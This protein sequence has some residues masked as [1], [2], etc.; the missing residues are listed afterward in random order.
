MTAPDPR[1]TPEP[2][3][4]P[5]IAALALLVA[6]AATAGLALHP[7]PALAAGGG[8]WTASPTAPTSG[9]SAT[10][11]RVTDDDAAADDTTVDDDATADDSDVPVGDDDPTVAV[12]DSGIEIEGIP[13]DDPIAAVV[14]DRRGKILE[15]PKTFA[16]SKSARGVKLR[17]TGWSAPTA[18][19]RG[20]VVVRSTHKGHRTLRGAGTI[21]L[22]GPDSCDD[23]TPIYRRAVVA[24]P[25]KAKVTVALPGCSAL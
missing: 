22:S 8:S 2:T 16:A 7:G 21:V 13:D 19:G 5:R 3:W 12:D 11:V 17:W 6:G 1:E 18:T 24:I 20:K 15:G 9:V 4:S 25:R 23:G 14:V 10:L